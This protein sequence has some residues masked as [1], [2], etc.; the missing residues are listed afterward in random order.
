MEKLI[1]QSP[2]YKKIIEKTKEISDIINKFN[3]DILNE[4]E[5]WIYD[6]KPE[7]LSKQMNLRLCYLISRGSVC[8]DYNLQ[9]IWRD[10]DFLSKIWLSLDTSLPHL[11][12]WTG[13]VVGFDEE[14][15]T[16][17]EEV[18]KFEEMLGKKLSNLA[19]LGKEFNEL[20]DDLDNVFETYS[21]R[22]L[23]DVSPKIY[24]VYV[25]NKKAEK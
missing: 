2:I 9:R 10:N 15:E 8:N 17:K 3:L 7:A 5:R 14:G 25:A 13:E 19:K 24:N 16:R 20:V 11:I 1:T 21:L 23:K 22:E 18:E 6:N 4:H 12:G